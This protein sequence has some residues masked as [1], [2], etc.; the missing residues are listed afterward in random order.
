MMPVAQQITVQLNGEPRSFLGPLTLL[1]ALT[2]L[3][4]ADRRGI[5]IAIDDVV[6]PRMAWPSREL[7]AGERVLVIQATQ[8]G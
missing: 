8:G 5:A 2:E 7:A 3:G 4:L 1:A 6:I